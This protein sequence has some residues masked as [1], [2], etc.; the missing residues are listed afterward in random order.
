MSPDRVDVAARLAL[1]ERLR[2]LERAVARDAFTRKAAELLRGRTH[3]LGNHLQ[4]VR[5]ASLE[6]EKRGA[7]PDAAEFITDLRAAAEQ[8]T[9]IL[10]ELLAAAR[11]EERNA[12]GPPVAPLVRAAVELA[13]PAV[14]G[15]VDFS[16]ELP[17]DAR[18]LCTA[19]ELEGLVLAALLDTPRAKVVLRA[20]TIAGKPWLQLLCIGARADRVHYEELV[21]GLA[22]QSGGEVSV[23]PGREGTELA[24]ELPVAR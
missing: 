2:P 12:W 13:R 1:V 20:R 7:G 3:E 22:T 24:I 17:D 21:E 11:P 4:I 5:L 19:D 16:C 23:S 10:L 8:A 6:L 18:S 9:T 14:P 15:G